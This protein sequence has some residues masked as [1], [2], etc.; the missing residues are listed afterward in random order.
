MLPEWL[1]PDLLRWLMLGFVAVVLAGMY[2]AIRIIQK[3]VLRIGL[4]LFLGIVVLVAWNERADLEGCAQ[5]CS[6]ELLGREVQ[7]PACRDSL[8][9]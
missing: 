9:G 6:C 7:V 4:V 3:V 5:N 2:F 1:S 8:G